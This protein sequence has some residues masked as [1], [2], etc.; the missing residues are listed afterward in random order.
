MSDDTDDLLCSDYRESL[1]H[2]NGNSDGSYG[3]LCRFR[4]RFVMSLE[5]LKVGINYGLYLIQSVLKPF[6]L[7]MAPWE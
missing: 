1:G 4:D 7:D 3:Y 2:L 6:S 5:I